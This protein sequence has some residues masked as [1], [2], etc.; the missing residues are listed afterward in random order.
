MQSIGSVVA[1]VL[2]AILVIVVLVAMSRSVRP[3]RKRPR[4]APS[5]VVP[6]RA[7]QP[8]RVPRNRISPGSGVEDLFT[9]LLLGMASVAM[10]KFVKSGGL[11]RLLNRIGTMPLTLNGRTTTIGAAIDSDTYIRDLFMDAV[12]RRVQTSDGHGGARPNIDLESEPFAA[13]IAAT[14][15]DAVERRMRERRI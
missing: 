11:T 3:R 1:L 2:L 12:K 10:Y 6:S 7:V 15:R 4:V 5:T 9:L 13:D 14:L 8:R